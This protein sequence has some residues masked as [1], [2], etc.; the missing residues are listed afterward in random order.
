MARSGNNYSDIALNQLRL[1]M[2]ANGVQRI[3]VKGLAPNDNSKNQP[4]VAKDEYSAFNILPAVDISSGLSAKG[5]AIIKATLSFFWLQSDG[6]ANPAPHAKLIYYP[7]YPEMRLSGFLL[8]SV[9][10]PSLLM[11]T[12]QNGRILFLGTTNDRRIIAW[13]ASA[14]S[15]IVREYNTLAGLE[16]L[17]VFRVLSAQIMQTGTSK[18]KLLTELRRIHLLNWINSKALKS[19][20]SIVRCDAP[21]CVGYTLEAELGISRNGRSEPDY[22]GWEIKAGEVSSFIRPPTARAVT[23]MTPEP[24]LGYY[25]EQGVEAFVRR[26]GYP[27]KLGRIDRINFGG[28]FRAG[29]RNIGTGL[30]LMLDGYDQNTRT[31]TNPGGSITLLDDRGNIAAG[32][33]FNRLVEI[34]MRKH[35]LAAYVPALV[36]H[37]NVRQYHYGPKVRLAEATDFG[38]FISA[39]ANGTIYYDPGIKIEGAATTAPKTKRRSQFRV[40]STNLALLYEKMYT[41][42]LIA[43]SSLQSFS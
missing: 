8:G 6:S 37:E 29:Q 9:N 13:V 7:Q 21:Q 26:Y 17:G 32:W 34:W 31:F 2:A 14:E 41:F 5:N 15:S 35:A 36:R 1:M 11:N 33:S 3:L 10:A 12:R 28:I 22:L 20:G 30:T 39:F 24:T 18:E 42:D 27:D 19:D 16:Q 25:S 40:S 4:Y 23:L 38:R 43:N